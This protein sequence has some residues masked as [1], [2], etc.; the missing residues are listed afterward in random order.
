MGLR[1]LEAVGWPASKVGDCLSAL[2]RKSGL[3][4]ARI[5]IPNPLQP[6][7]GWPDS[8]WIERAAK[9]L[10]LEAEPVEIAFRDLEDEL[11][12][13][14]PALV[15]VSD[16]FFLAVFRGNRRTLLV[17]T[18]GLTLREV[19]VRDLAQAI[20]GPAERG[21]RSQLERLLH[22]ARIPRSQRERTLS[23]L[24]NEQL[25][26]TRFDQGWILRISPGARPLPWMRQVKA[27][28]NGI[29]LIVAHAA[30]YLLWLAS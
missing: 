6:N 23:L 22:E 19:P 8:R 17:L 1:E 20:R 13:C 4:S 21:T 3:A 9:Q 11:P 30:Q 26:E 5:E 16:A 14:Y 24:L 2:V 25:G 27:I 28:H 7:S 10:A 29:G 18:P 12:T 15:R